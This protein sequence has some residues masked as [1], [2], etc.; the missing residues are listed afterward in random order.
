M[1]RLL[2]MNS[3]VCAYTPDDSI[4][5]LLEYKYIFFLRKK[6][7]KSMKNEIFQRQRQF[8]KK[9][10]QRGKIQVILLDIAKVH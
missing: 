6:S 9:G 1:T 8:F 7:G 4:Y 10:I 3:F 2:W 5:F